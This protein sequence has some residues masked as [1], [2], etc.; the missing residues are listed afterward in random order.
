LELTP[1]A[2][3][4]GRLLAGRLLNVHKQ[5]MDWTN[6]A[7]TVFTPLEYTSIGL[8]EDE[9]IQK[10]GDG[11]FRVYAHP[12]RPLEWEY[13]GRER[14]LEGYVKLLTDMDDKVIGLHYLGPNAGEVG[15][16]WAIAFKLGAKKEHFD[17]TVGIHPT[18]SENF[19]TFMEEGKGQK[20]SC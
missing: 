14:D 3:L 18:S 10:Y 16:G 5:L 9:V 17:T 13:L 12:F 7:T 11:N 15:Q 20:G 8:S 1:T 4:D 2:I 6:I 19:T